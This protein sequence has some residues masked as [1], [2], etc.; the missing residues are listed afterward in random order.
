MEAQFQ[1]SLIACPVAVAHQESPELAS[2]AVLCNLLEEIV[3]GVEEETEARREVVD[4]EPSF[5]CPV[6]ILQTIPQS[7]REFL[8]RGGP[9]FADMVAADRNG[10]EARGLFCSE[11]DGVGD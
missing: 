9:G 8:E 3:V 6:H 5:E 2:R 1:A 10:V 4:G 11:F 7:E